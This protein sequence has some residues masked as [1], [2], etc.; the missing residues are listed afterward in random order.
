MR[1][2]LLT[3]SIMFLLTAV[4]AKVSAQTPST[5][6][7][8]QS[9]GERLP[10][11]IK[12]NVISGRTLMLL[13]A[14]AE[15]HEELGIPVTDSEL[16][17]AINQQRTDLQLGAPPNS[18]NAA[19]IVEK[20]GIADLLSFAIDRGAITKTATGT[21]VTLSTTP[22]ALRTGFGLLDTPGRWESSPVE[23]KLSFSATFSST[24][25]SNGDF[26]SFTSGE[27]KY[28]I[29]GNRSPRDSKLLDGVRTNLQKRFH[30][31]D[32][33]LDR[34]CQSFLNPADPERN[35]YAFKLQ[36]K[37]NNWV[38][39]HQ[40]DPLGFIHEQLLEFVRPLR[41]MNP[42]EKGQMKVCVATVLAGQQSIQGGLDAVTEA[43]KAY[44]AEHPQQFSVAA[45]Y[46]R[47][48][49]LSDYYAA[50]L[51]YGYDRKAM[52]IN[53]NAEAD[54]N[55]ESTTAAGMPLRSLRAYSVELGFNSKT[56]ANGRLDSSL[57]SKASRDKALDSK[58]IVIGEAKLNLHLSDVLRLP[59][60]LTYANRETQTIKQGWQFNVGINALLD[61]VLRRK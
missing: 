44:L 12:T 22:Y 59:L 20:P 28:I 21:G 6:S 39:E 4:A 29:A 30:A 19:S 57:S 51:L 11:E 26:S 14:E 46:I 3:L 32:T 58:S 33:A 35:D 56:F 1:K 23:R 17:A 5:S 60:T 54:W 7:V 42:V 61:E 37:I 53:L 48:A 31:A 10:D 18:P 34:D 27:V 13:L 8:S 38:K 47:D 43:T 50:K 49:T 15:A 55:K 40:S 2:V 24:D 45:L 25:V 16:R 9:L 52:T 41:P 36:A